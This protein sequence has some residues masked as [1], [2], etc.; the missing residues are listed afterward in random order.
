MENP[1]G[2][3]CMKKYISLILIYYL[4]LLIIR[5][6]SLAQKPT[7]ILRVLDVGQGDS[8]LIDY[9][10]TFKVLIDAGTGENIEDHLLKYFLLPVCNFDAVYITHLHLDHF[11]GMLPILDKCNIGILWFNDV[12]LTTKVYRAFKQRIAENTNINKVLTTISVGNKIEYGDLK[13]ITLWP[14]KDFYSDFKPTDDLNQLTTVLFIDYRDFEAVLM[15]D[16]ESRVLGTID[17]TQTM[18]LIQGG[19][20]VLKI[21]HHGSKNGLTAELMAI[22]KPKVCVISVGN[23]NSYGHPSDTTLSLLKSSGCDIRRTDLDGT[24]EFKLN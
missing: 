14:T 18:P 5:V 15:G 6:T 17:W 9:K 11:G 2:H 4:F 12:P 10:N 19:L 1:K 24:I 13:I 21:P 23:P 20:D 3:A 8:I 16:A 7:F 22:L